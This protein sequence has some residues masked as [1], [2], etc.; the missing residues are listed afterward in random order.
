M[1]L[2]CAP[3]FAQQVVEE[4]LLDVK[5]TIVYLGNMGTFSFSW[6]HHMLILDKILHWFEANG[7]ALNPLQCKWAIQETDCLGYS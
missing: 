7:F 3:D 6:K 5:D 2:K 4:V 1:G